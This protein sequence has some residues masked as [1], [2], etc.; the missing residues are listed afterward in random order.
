MNALD[1]WI[2]IAVYDFGHDYPE[3]LGV[4]ESRE[5]AKMAK[6]AWAETHA[7]DPITGYQVLHSAVNT[8]C[9]N[10]G[11]WESI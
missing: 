1:L 4:F 9:A 10:V 8:V 5:L 6:E 11:G 3:V 7:K 2:L